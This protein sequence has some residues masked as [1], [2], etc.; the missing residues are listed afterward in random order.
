MGTNQRKKKRFVRQAIFL[1]SFLL[2]ILLGYKLLNQY[3]LSGKVIGVRFVTPDG[4]ETPRFSLEIA[5]S[6]EKRNKG[7]MFRKQMDSEAGMIFIYP[8]ES[9]QRFWMKNTYIPLD[10]I[11]LDSKLVVVGLLENVPVLNTEPRSIPTPSMYA[12]EL[13]AGTAKKF[14]ISAGAKAS[15]ETE[16]PKSK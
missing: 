3:L 11:F 6:E 9:I 2:V 7:L 4:N 15:F 12:I 1:L 13:N 14:S 8:Q 16:L 5:D 10:M